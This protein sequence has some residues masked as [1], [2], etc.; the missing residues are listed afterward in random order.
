MA[1]FEDSNFMA[2]SKAIGSAFAAKM[3]DFEDSNFSEK[4]KAIGFAFSA[5]SLILK[6]LILR[7][8]VRL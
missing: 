2:K 8:K 1:D 4:S 7:Q 3:A 5:N 6:I